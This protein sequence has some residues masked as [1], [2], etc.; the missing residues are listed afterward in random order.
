MLEKNQQH[1]RQAEETPITRATFKMSLR[2]K[3]MAQQPS[4]S[5]R[6]TM[7]IPNLMNI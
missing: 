6:V 1:F 5:S 4:S 7:K 3:E 2:Y